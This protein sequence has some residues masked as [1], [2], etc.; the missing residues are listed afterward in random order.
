MFLQ[1]LCDELWVYVMTLE[2]VNALMEGSF[3]RRLL[4]CTVSVCRK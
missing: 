4:G 2:K 1:K 3:W